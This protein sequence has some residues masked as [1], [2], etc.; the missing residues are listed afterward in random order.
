MPTELV[1]GAKVPRYLGDESTLGIDNG[2]TSMTFLHM[3]LELA[4]T[5]QRLTDQTLQQQLG[6]RTTSTERHPMG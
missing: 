6:T 2:G 3:E 4:T 5:Y 1:V